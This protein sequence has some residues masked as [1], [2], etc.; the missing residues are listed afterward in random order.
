MKPRLALLGD[1]AHAVHPMA[2]QGVNL[3]LGDADR[4]AGAVGEAL[5]EGADYG[6]SGWLEEHYE[7]PRRRANLLMMSALDGVRAAFAAQ[8]GPIR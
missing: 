6:D 7:E 1:A 5:A 2:G 3:G 8:A 4:L